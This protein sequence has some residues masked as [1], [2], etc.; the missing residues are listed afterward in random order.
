MADVLDKSTISAYSEQLSIDITQHLTYVNNFVERLKVQ[1]GDGSSVPEFDFLGDA[2]LKEVLA[3]TKNFWS[4]TNLTYDIEPVEFTTT[5]TSTRGGNSQSAALNDYSLL[6]N[7]TTQQPDENNVYAM[8]NPDVLLDKLLDLTAPDTPIME[9]PWIQYVAMKLPSLPSAPF[10][11]QD[12]KE[13]IAL[14]RNRLW[15]SDKLDSLESELLA[16]VDQERLGYLRGILTRG[17][18]KLRYDFQ[19]KLHE[20]KIKTASKGFRNV[21]SITYLQTHELYWSYLG[22][23]YSLYEEYLK[24]IL[25]QANVAYTNLLSVE[26]L[27][28][29]FTKH[30]N[31]ML[32]AIYGTRLLV[33]QARLEQILANFGL[34]RTLLIQEMLG[35]QK[36]MSAEAELAS[37]RNKV[38]ILSYQNDLDENKAIIAFNDNLLK[39]VQVLSDN[40]RLFLAELQEG[41]EKK[42]FAQDSLFFKQEADLEIK[43]TNL[44]NVGSYAKSNSDVLASQLAAIGIDLQAYNT[45]SQL[46]DAILAAYTAEFD[47]YLTQ[48]SLE[49]QGVAN[50]QLI[51]AAADAAMKSSSA[52]NITLNTG[53]GT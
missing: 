29:D 7:P 27:H 21:N 42:S 23:L 15:R 45:L 5:T 31:E 49:Q 48:I 40:N 13:G 39:G 35:Q 2:R 32:V 28:R 19:I 9:L 33:N 1:L 53:S 20:E 50:L 44:E 10:L 17:L 6:A 18:E 26:S 22:S 14:H 46:F 16:T 12:L 4:N 52:A 11:D 3:K 38:S 43:N 30:I 8:A 36:L 25:D 51:A 34:V 47:K 41:I 24:G 37:Y